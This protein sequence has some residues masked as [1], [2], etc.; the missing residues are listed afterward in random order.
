V[1]PNGTKQI[2]FVSRTDVEE[3]GPNEDATPVLLVCATYKLTGT[4]ENHRSA[5]LYRLLH[6]DPVRGSRPVDRVTGDVPAQS[7]RLEEVGRHAK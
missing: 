1:S 7:L 6:I 5:I 2:R 4:G 3:L